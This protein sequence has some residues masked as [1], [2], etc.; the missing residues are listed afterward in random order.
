MGIGT[1]VLFVL[2]FAPTFAWLWQRWTMSIWHNGHG[3]FVPLVVA[4]LGYQALKSDKFKGEES[5][6]WGFAFFI[7]GLLMVVADTG[8]RTQLLSAFGLILCL[9][10]A[11]LLLLGLR[12]ARALVFPLLLLFLMLPIPTAF[13]DRFILLLRRIS[14]TGCA[15]LVDMTGLPV[16]REF[17]TLHMP[18]STLVIADA[19]SGFSTL[20]A[21]V[22]M[23][24]ILCYMVSS[25]ARRALILLSCV[26]LAIGCNI[27]RCTALAYMVN[28]GGS[29]ILNTSW[30][31]LT[32]IISFSAALILL[33]MV[34]FIG[35]Q[36]EGNLDSTIQPVSPVHRARSAADADPGHSPLLPGTERE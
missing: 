11:V 19:C 31:P 36:K 15:Y 20:Y 4:Y 28:Y 6:A 26:P 2:V 16:L 18:G 29:E 35:S 1:L 34:A 3:M 9:I 12:R 22:T 17:T 33:F 30:H 5:S 23:A 10:G 13:V 21:S 8:I 7:P 24:L 27:I 25:N 32:G 14:A